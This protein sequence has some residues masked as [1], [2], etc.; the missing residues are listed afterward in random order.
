MKG[1]IASLT[2]LRGVAAWFVVGYHFRSVFVEQFPAVEYVLS[3]GY[4]AVDL[5]FLLSGF[6]LYYT[7][8]QYFDRDRFFYSSRRFLFDRFARIY[9]L[10]IVILCA[11]LINPIALL[12][13]SD[14]GEIGDRY[15]ALY[16]LAS[17]FLVQNWGGFDSLFWNVPAWSIS[18]EFAAYLIFPLVA[19]V[20]FSLRR[21]VAVVWLLGLFGL[22]VLLHFYFGLI[23]MAENIS[24][25]GT[26][27]CVFEFLMGLVLGRIF[28]LSSSTCNVFL[29]SFI[30]ISILI[31]FA[32]G[33]RSGVPDFYFVPALM[34]LLLYSLARDRGLLA[35]LLSLPIFRYLG[36]ISYSTY[37]SHYFVLDWVKFLSISIGLLQF[38]V[39]LL[40]VFVMSVFLF[41]HVEVPARVYLKSKFSHLYA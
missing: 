31:L 17:L 28:I 9:P 35:R 2:G 21:G 13:F 29:L 27:R 39:Y 40:L 8:S 22:F 24:K 12:L 33:L 15:P 6:I 5:F 20:V 26:L 4:Y 19:L 10:H 7:A 38:F 36:V 41:R 14:S 16:F 32:V 25:Y 34:C 30:Q 11:Y 18:S 3:H 1:E 37:L 23:S